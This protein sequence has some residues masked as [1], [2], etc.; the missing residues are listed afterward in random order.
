MIKVH[1]EESYG[2]TMCRRVIVGALMLL[3]ATSSCVRVDNAFGVTID[4]S[5]YR[6]VVIE[7][8]S[9]VPVDQC[10]RV[11]N[12]LEVSVQSD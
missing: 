1:S 3:L 2:A 8:Q 5:A 7:I 6:G 10:S 12:D 11:L 4:K 9:T